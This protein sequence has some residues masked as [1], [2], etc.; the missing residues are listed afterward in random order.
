MTKNEHRFWLS[1]NMQSEA[2]LGFNAFNTKKLTGK[3]VIDFVKFRQMVAEAHPF[4][5]E[6]IEAV[7]PKP[8]KDEENK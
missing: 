2:Y 6:L 8:Q 4:D 7:L 1:V 5:D 3:D